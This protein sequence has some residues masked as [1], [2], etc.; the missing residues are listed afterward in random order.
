MAEDLRKRKR[1]TGNG[2]WDSGR[3]KEEKKEY[4]KR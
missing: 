3:L 4:R 1:N 2:K